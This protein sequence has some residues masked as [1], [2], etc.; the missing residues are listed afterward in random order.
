LG[1]KFNAGFEQNVIEV[2]QG[3]LQKNRLIKEDR[4][5]RKRKYFSMWFVSFI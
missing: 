5:E 4:K 1:K 2:F 3:L